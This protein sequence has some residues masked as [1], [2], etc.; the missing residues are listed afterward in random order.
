[1][2]SRIRGGGTRPDQ[3]R[4]SAPTR[5]PRRQR[6]A[7]RSECLVR[8]HA[9]P[10]TARPVGEAP[11][12][13]AFRRPP[14]RGD[15]PARLFARRGARLAEVLAQT[16]SSLLAA[17]LTVPW[18]L[19]AARRPRPRS[20]PRGRHCARQCWIGAPP[21]EHPGAGCALSRGRSDRVGSRRRRSRR[22]G[23]GTARWGQHGAGR[24]ATG[25]RN[26][27]R[28]RYDRTTALLRR[29]RRLQQELTADRPI[30]L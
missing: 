10:G 14:S 15:V 20:A 5:L 12:P 11:N 28:S 18:T 1:V 23:W 29:L 6:A 22:I 3:S 17:E 9:R 25:I 4:A 24:A 13:T 27:T 26:V 7:R 16:R 21:G 2:T 19:Q 8:L 30:S